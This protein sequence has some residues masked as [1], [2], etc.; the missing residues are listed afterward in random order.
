MQSMVSL[1][2]IALLASSLA[3]LLSGPAAADP[4]AMVGGRPLE[5]DE[6]G[7]ALVRA[8]GRNAITGLVDWVLVEQEARSR[9]IT[10]TDEEVLARRDL[11]VDLAVRA[12]YVQARISAE[13]Y[14]RQAEARGETSED[15]RREL[16]EGLSLRAV[17]ARLLAERMLAGR[18]DLSDDAVRAYYART[19]GPRYLVAH[20]LTPGRA[21]A[22]R[23]AGALESRPELWSEL[24]LRLSL[25]RESVPFKGRLAPVPASSDLGKEFEGMLP[26]DMRVHQGPSG[27]HVFRLVSEIPASPESFAEANERARAELL[28]LETAPLYEEL[29]ADLHRNATVVVN[30]TRDEAVQNAVGAGV[31]AYVNGEPVPEAEL[32]EVLIERLGSSMLGSYIERELILQEAERRGL[33]V[34]DEELDRRMA[35]IGRQLYEHY[36]LAGEGNDLFRSAGMSAEEAGADLARLHADPEDVRATL[37][38]EKMAGGTQP[39]SDAAVAALYA[40]MHGDRA[41]VKEA[42]FASYADARRA[43]DALR[44]GM[45]FDAMARAELRGTGLWMTGALERVVT[46]EDAVWPHVS[47]LEPGDVSEVF[48]RGG[49]YRII[50]VL[51]R[52][53]P[54]DPPPFE[55]VRESLEQEAGL[56]QVRERARALLLRLKA[57]A[58]RAGTIEVLLD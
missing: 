22:T 6:F 47:G 8:F 11:A 21:D 54:T 42:S 12:A 35:A 1:R 27:W 28:A 17:S 41:V 20:I 14:R 44:R 58:R 39:V 25:D 29:L 19:R 16:S 32:A 9:G 3:C 56:R 18:V 49:Q 37:L 51:E 4:V 38:A 31:A 30:L 52:I 15:L 55:S 46:A 53:H 10:V 45:D 13:D 36:R 26:G 34:S 24:V 23:V 7:A 33:S 50:E 2:N 40:E 57:E 43:Y 5:R 48:E